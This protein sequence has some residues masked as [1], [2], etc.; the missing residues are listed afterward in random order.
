LFTIVGGE[1]K[2][3][4][5]NTHFDTTR[6][7]VEFSGAEAVDFL[8]EV[9]KHPEQRADFKGNMDVQALENFIK[10]KGAEN[11]PLVMITITNNSGGGQPRYSIIP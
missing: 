1:G 5:N 7:N 2:Y 4:P 11:I 9:G 6:A 3:I 10:E 8:V